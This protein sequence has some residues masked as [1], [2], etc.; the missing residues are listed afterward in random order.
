MSHARSRVQTAINS[1]RLIR[2][3]RCERCHK[4]GK[5]GKDGRSTIQCHHK[6]YRKPLDV[7]W[8][9]AK[10]H[11]METPQRGEKNS[12][13]KLTKRQANAIRKDPRSHRVLGEV[14]GVH[15]AQIGRIKRGESYSAAPK[16]TK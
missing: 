12:F 10:C 2:P 6:D 7:V 16:E 13:A 1:G 8:L 5:S 14:Y 4:I 3:S 11:R 9:C 15:H